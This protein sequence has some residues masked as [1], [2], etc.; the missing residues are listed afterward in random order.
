MH[1][2]SN[3]PDSKN[4]IPQRNRGIIVGFDPGLT[5]GIAIMDLK[6]NILSVKSFK[7]IS[8]AEIIYNI[9]NYGKAVLISTDVYPP[10]KMVKKLATTLNAKIHH[11]ARDM[12]VG[13][14]IELVE[15]Y[16]GQSNQERSKVVA[17]ELIPQDAH[18]RDALAASIRTYKSYQK[19]LEHIENRSLEASLTAEDEDLVKRMVIQGT[20]ISSAIRMVQEMHEEEEEQDV[21][22]EVEELDYHNSTVDSETVSKLKNRI[23]I[24]ENQINNLKTR[25]RSM[26]DRIKD[27]EIEVVKLQEKMGKLQYEFTQNILLDKELIN[28]ISLIK[29][30]QDKYS[31]EKALR[32]ELERNLES[33]GNIQTIKPTENAI[34]VKIIENFTRD[35][36]MEACQYWKI[37]K[38]DLVLLESSEGGGSQTATQLVNM[39]VKA[40]LIRDKMSHHALEEFEKHMVPLLQAD[41]MD[42]EMIDQFAIVNPLKLDKEIQKWKEEV[43]NKKIKESNDEILK[44][45]DEYRARRK[46]NME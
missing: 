32:M 24:Q 6:G 11:P 39:G 15:S 26:E 16:L 35:G 23:K 43:E 14:K 5:A 21:A 3:L 12:S 28:K 27:Y 19:K 22:G 38:G 34:P 45:F 29:K 4:E 36:I 37:N 10:P 31:E 13:T 30:L 41:N 44:A 42:L 7:E 46:R 18:Q 33:L 2:T 40:V 17:S 25:N 20:A 1:E 8:R 9:I